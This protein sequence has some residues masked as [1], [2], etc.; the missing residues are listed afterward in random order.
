MPDDLSRLTAGKIVPAELLEVA[1]RIL[2]LF[3]GRLRIATADAEWITIQPVNL[4]EPQVLKDLMEKQ[5]EVFPNS[6][7][8]S[9]FQVLCPWDYRGGRG[10][11]LRYL[12]YGKPKADPGFW[13]V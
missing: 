12:G 11:W 9:R 6:Q 3:P 2:G 4:T 1:N 7:Q 13:W 8:M 5:K 10:V